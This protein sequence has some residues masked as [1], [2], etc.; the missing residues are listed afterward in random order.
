MER[1]NSESQAAWRQRSSGDIGALVCHSHSLELGH[2]FIASCYIQSDL[3]PEPPDY[4]EFD[5]EI[6]NVGRLPSTNPSSSHRVSVGKRLGPSNASVHRFG[7][8]FIPHSTYRIN[9]ILPIL[10]DRFL[11]IGS[12]DGLSVLD[13]LPAL[14]GGTS[15]SNT[16]VLS[17]RDAKTR[18]IWTGDAVHQLALLEMTPSDT[19]GIVQGV[20]LAL[21][22]S[23]LPGEVHKKSVRMYSL[24]SLCNLVTLMVNQP[25]RSSCVT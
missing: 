24:A 11:L 10:S 2:V 15:V 18:V 20:V 14:H 4:P 12:D 21:V 23:N 17:L 22:S 9:A 6:L 1:Y 25:V 7:S 16:G 19:T 3:S 13:T 8:R 5:P